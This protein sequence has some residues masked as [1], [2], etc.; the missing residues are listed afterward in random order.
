[1]RQISWHTRQKVCS[2]TTHIYN[3]NHH[4]W[5]L[6]NYL[7]SCQWGFESNY[8]HF[9][10][11]NYFDNIRLI[12]NGNLNQ[13]AT[14]SIQNMTLNL[15]ISSAKCCSYRLGLVVLAVNVLTGNI[16]D[17]KVHGTN[18]GP[19]WVLSVPD[20]PH[21]GPMNLAIRD[22]ACIIL[23]WLRKC[24]SFYNKSVKCRMCCVNIG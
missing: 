17:S 9:H 22:I 8:S 13:N 3:S 12:V 1:M 11:Q 18:M 19:T 10:L 5:W 4:G 6:W 15:K 2:F 14:F 16:P 21:V 7:A 20:G 24:S 23:N